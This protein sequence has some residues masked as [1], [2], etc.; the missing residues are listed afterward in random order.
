MMKKEY[1]A[2]GIGSPL[3]DFTIEVSDSV[4]DDLGLKKGQMHLIDEKKSR[5]IFSKVKDYKMDKTPGGSSANTLAG[6][7]ILGGKG[8]LFGKVG[9][10]ANADYYIDETGKSGIKSRLLRHNSMTGH[11]ITLVTPDFGRTFATH[12]GAAVHFRKEEDPERAAR[13]PR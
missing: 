13:L 6:L 11:A 12:L 7:A 5:D 9:N 4:L 10:D 8:V 1:D 2:A 3:V